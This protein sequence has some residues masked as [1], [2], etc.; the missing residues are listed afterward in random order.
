MT[1]SHLS[2]GKKGLPQFTCSVY[3]VVIFFPSLSGDCASFL[4]RDKTKTNL[5]KGRLNIR[6]GGGQEKPWSY[7]ILSTGIIN[8]K[9]AA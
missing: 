2:G 9:L 7:L 6:L 3:T 8:A 5:S 4:Q 1:G